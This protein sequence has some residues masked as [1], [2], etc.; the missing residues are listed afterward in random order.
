[1]ADWFGFIPSFHDATLAK[2]QL[3]DG[4]ASITLKAFRMTDE[5][6]ARGSYVLDRHVHI[7]IHLTDVSG[8]RLVGNSSSIL[9]G[10]GLR[11]ISSNLSGWETCDGPRAGDFEICWDTSYGLEGALFARQMYFELTPIRPSNAANQG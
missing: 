6:D 1:V 9:A 5:V 3:A 10:L 7:D 11:R 8:V 2:L 4:N